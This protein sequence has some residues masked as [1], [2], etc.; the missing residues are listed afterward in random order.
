LTE[1]S[2]IAV[3]EKPRNRPSIREPGLWLA[4]AAA[5][6]VGAVSFHWSSEYFHNVCDD[7]LI[8]L[9]YARNA[10]RGLGFV[11][12]PGERAEG[13][14]NFLWV[15][16]LAAL[17]PMSDGTAAGFVRLAAS[18]SIALAVM[19][20]LLVFALGRLIW[21][22]RLIPTLCAIGLCV[23]DNSYTVWAMQA[24][25][26]HLL[27][28]AMLLACVLMWG[29]DNRWSAI[30]AGL[31]LAAAMMTR[32]DAALFVVAVGASELLWVWSRVDRRS[33]LRRFVWVFGTT[34]F[35]YGTYFAWRYS[36][37]GYL[38][39]NTYYVKASGLS[40]DALERGYW[41][42]Y[43]FLW[44]RSFVPLL[45]LGAFV[46]IKNRI[47]RPLLLWV[48]LHTAYVVYIGGDF[49]PGHRFFVVSIPVI[50]LLI[51]YVVYRGIDWAE[52]RWGTTRRIAWTASA[53]VA[54][55]VTTVGIQGLRLGPVQTEI[56]QWRDEVQRV[57]AFMEWVGRTSPEGSSIATGDIGSS[58]YYANLHVYDVFGLIDP[59]VA[60]QDA[61]LGEGKAGHE[62][63]ADAE[64]LLAKRPAL[65]KRGYLHRD[66]YPDGYYFDASIPEE[67]DEMGIWRRSD[68]ASEGVLLPGTRIGFESKPYPGWSATGEAFERW[69]S[70]ARGRRQF[71]I[72]GRERWFASSYHPTRGDSVVGSLRSAPFQLVGDRLLIRVAGGRDPRALRVELLVDERI[73][74]WATGHDSEIFA[75]HSWDVSELRGRMATLRV[76]DDARGPW[77]HIMVD[78][79]QQWSANDR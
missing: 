79:I 43:R 54:V 1:P 60:H 39:P 18:V 45:A 4:I 50:A 3:P 52:Q 70:N 57:R 75:L 33:A 71:P 72:W 40:A 34:T 17:H 30:G 25:E 23:A 51:G 8:S 10:A 28:F 37:F 9:Q 11:F 5:A 47:I 13:Y 69:P 6:A 55:L 32:P 19:D 53:L 62:K 73:V 12:N 36:Y 31:S 76:I 59:V 74:A 24:L 16:L 21:W 15:A 42:L 64:Y 44:I 26:S 46:G 27:L 49:Y 63:R 66:L 61:A 77:G 35:V 58:G 7:T 78:E 29:S 22:K 14:T 20:V 67:L 56:Y 41:Y 2:P 38:L 48:L 68:F 65:V